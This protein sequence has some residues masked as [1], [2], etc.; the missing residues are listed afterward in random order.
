MVT[1]PVYWVNDEADHRSLQQDNAVSMSFPDT[2]DPDGRE[3]MS[4]AAIDLMNSLLQEREYRL[5]CKDYKSNDTQHAQQSTSNPFRRHA[6]ILAHDYSGHFVYPD[7]AR[8]IKAH[9][10]FDNIT[11]DRLHLTRPPFV[12]DIKSNE[13]TKYFDDATNEISNS[14]SDTESDIRKPE[15]TV[16]HV[17]EP[18]VTQVDG[19]LTQYS[20]DMT[21]LPKTSR[22]GHILTLAK[23]KIGK[24]RTR[25]R[26]RDRVLRDQ[27]V[28]GIAL[29]LRKKGAFAGYTYRRPQFLLWDLEGRY[30]LSS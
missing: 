5:S 19:A 27:D 3:T 9:P 17:M 21:Q 8:D 26:A 2:R 12:P 18:R 10:F 6:N 16:T 1:P 28:G 22:H 24:D 14:S 29:E 4:I 11:W 23:G 20:T 15:P 13:D 7:D 30:H 25:K